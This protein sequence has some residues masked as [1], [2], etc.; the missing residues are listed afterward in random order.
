MNQRK[1]ER[2]K[3]GSKEGKKVTFF[4]KKKKKVHLLEK[5][6]KKMAKFRDKF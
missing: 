1:R 3:I 2:G 4:Q 6:T 5:T